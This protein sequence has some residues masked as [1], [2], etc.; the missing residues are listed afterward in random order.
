MAKSELNIVLGAMTFGAAGKE[1]VRVHEQKD[2]EA[3]LDVF[4]Q[5]GHSEID[6][7]RAYGLGTSEESLGK[8]DW[9]GRGLKI[10]TKILPNLFPNPV[11]GSVIIKHTPED[12]RLHLNYSL[13]ALNTDKLDIWYLHVPDR[14]T[15]YDVTLKAVD[16]LYKEGK[17]NRF[18]ISNY[19]ACN[20]AFSWEVA[21]M[22]QLC[23]ANGWVQPT[24]FQGT[25]NAL[26]RSVEPELFPCL[27]KYGISFYEYNPLA[28]GF[29]TGRYHSLNEQPEA[30]TRFDPNGF[31]G[32]NYRLKYWK[33]PYFKAIETVKAVADKHNLTLAEVA[34]RWVSHHSLMKREF[35]DAVIIGGS[36]IEHIK[37]NLVDLEKGPLPDEVVSVLDEAWLGVLPFASK[38]YG[39]VGLQA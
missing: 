33:E 36:S 25:Y 14:S 28:G 4:Q 21:E 19:T 5:H 20:G 34:L 38:Y 2:I 11:F 23:R 30:K 32:Q 13:K 31:L 7:A 18:G 35:G 39:E 16:E 10:G 24:V 6:T 17:F 12:L 37:Q 3:I 22:V 15:P 26:H 1:G 27:R 9:Q 29:F 8:I